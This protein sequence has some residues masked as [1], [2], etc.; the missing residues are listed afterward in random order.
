MAVLSIVMSLTLSCCDND[1]Q[2]SDV[3]VRPDS[4]VLRLGLL[5]TYESLPFY[6]ADHYG[7]SDSL[8]LHL[9]LFTYM[10]AMDVDTSFARGHVDGSV[11]DLVKYSIMKGHGDSVSIVFCNDLSI[12]MLSSRNSRISDSKNLKEKIFA[13]TRNSVLDM[14]ADKVLAANKFESY[15]LNKP[16]INNLRIRTSMLLQNQYDGTFLPEPWSSIAIAGGCTKLS[17]TSDMDEMSDQ[18]CIVFND[19]VLKHR[20]SDVK[21]LEQTYNAGV[22]YI[23]SHPSLSK[24]F[25]SLLHLPDIYGDSLVFKL[26]HF[27]HARKVSEA[28]LSTSRKWAAG[29]GLL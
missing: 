5:P 2:D 27:S 12:T 19:S 17:V 8:D 15:E 18:Y 3:S 28:S 6:V 21:K 1:S 23:N 22:D 7:L 16:Q 20:G 29:R 10:S 25:I 4:T 14:Y 11:C 24:E 13:L 26:P 9:G